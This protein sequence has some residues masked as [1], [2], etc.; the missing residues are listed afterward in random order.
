VVSILITCDVDFF[1][2]R[3]KPKLFDTVFEFKPVFS[4]E[5]SN[6][7]G[8]KRREEEAI[9]ELKE[10]APEN[11]ISVESELLE[12]RLAPEGNSDGLEALTISNTDDK[13]IAIT[14]ANPLAYIFV[15][16]FFQLNAANDNLPRVDAYP[17]IELVSLT[18]YPRR[19]TI[20]FAPADYFDEEYGKIGEQS[21]R[22]HYS[23][24][25][26][27]D[28]MNV[29]RLYAVRLFASRDEILPYTQPANDNNFDVSEFR[30]PEIKYA[31]V[32]TS[33]QLSIASEIYLAEIGPLPDSKRE[34]LYRLR[35]ESISTPKNSI[36]TLVQPEIKIDYEP[37]VVTEDYVPVKIL[38]E[39]TVESSYKLAKVNT[40]NFPVEDNLDNLIKL[41]TNDNEPKR[42][43]H[44]DISNIVLQ[45]FSKDKDEYSS[46]QELVYQEADPDSETNF[47]PTEAA[48]DNVNHREE[49]NNIS[50]YKDPE[51]RWNIFEWKFKIV[52]YYRN[53][54]TIIDKKLRQVYN[55]TRKIISKSV[56]K[57]SDIYN[58]LTGYLITNKKVKRNNIYNTQN[59]DR[60]K[61]NTNSTKLNI[62]EDDIYYGLKG[63][64]KIPI[65]KKLHSIQTKD[66]SQDKIDA[67]EDMAYNI[68]LAL[69]PKNMTIGFQNIETGE[70]YCHNGKLRIAGPSLDKIALG[71]VF[72]FYAQN[73]LIDFSQ[74]VTIQDN[75]VLEREKNFTEFKTGNKI[76]YDRLL[77]QTLSESS[78]T[79]FNHL[80]YIL[81]EGNV[82]LGLIRA[83]KS[84]RYMGL[85]SIEINDIHQHNSNYMSNVLDVEALLRLGIAIENNEILNPQYS[86]T[87]KDTLKNEKWAYIFNGIHKGTCTP[88]GMGQMGVHEDKS[89]SNGKWAIA[90]IFDDFNGDTMFNQVYEQE[91]GKSILKNKGSNLGF[92]VANALDMSIKGF[93][94]ILIGN[95]Y[96]GGKF[97][98]E[99]G[100]MLNDSRLNTETLNSSVNYKK[101]LYLKAA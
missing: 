29:P 55:E 19:Y 30:A 100:I 83:R 66:F 77:Y 61:S 60:V 32:V 49:R 58:R 15:P 53:P 81:G 54:K 33:A 11:E 26:P 50:D 44:Q 70:F 59:I 5:T 45:A 73:N 40:R 79:A 93:M 97:K 90:L 88:Y 67:W 72:A 68:K 56:N 65:P 37:E 48:N 28:Y 34:D 8:F 31:D 39:A 47:F 18:P 20:V 2:T 69:G 78:D 87:F 86:K 24:I 94:E 23:E 84:L 75:L 21:E 27:V 76:K 10:E 51:R 52:K 62:S 1:G 64:T 4:D 46:N 80:I 17:K 57:I 42:N 9:I 89:V 101:F 38:L 3:F 95:K 35:A 63:P 25:E 99:L 96:D 36:E 85:E 91:N 74:Q 14:R 92:K 7:D 98:D 41:P 16:D 43:Q 13:K 22:V 12:D 82:Q 6:G 71:L